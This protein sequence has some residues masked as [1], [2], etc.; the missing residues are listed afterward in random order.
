MLVAVYFIKGKVKAKDNR[1]FILAA[2]INHKIDTSP[3][4]LAR[5][6]RTH[7]IFYLLTEG[8]S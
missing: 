6:L 3:E 5:D 7:V 8:H 1:R 4:R 2:G